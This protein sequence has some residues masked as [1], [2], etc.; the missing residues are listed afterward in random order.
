LGL[1]PQSPLGVVT[2]RFGLV[3]AAP[4]GPVNS[5]VNG[6]A[7]GADQVEQPPDLGQSERNG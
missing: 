4:V 5:Q 1:E 6:V 2:A 7:G 3:R